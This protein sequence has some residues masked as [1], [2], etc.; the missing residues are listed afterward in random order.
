VGRDSIVGIA[1]RYGLDGPGSNPGGGTDV[2]QPSRPALRP[3]QAPIQWIPVFLGDKVAG[4]VVA[5]AAILPSDE[6]KERVALYHPS[7]SGPSWPGL[8]WTLTFTILPASLISF[9]E[10]VS[11][12]HM[13][14]DL[15][16]RFE[17]VTLYR[18]TCS[19][20]S[21]RLHGI[22]LNTSLSIKV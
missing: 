22:T 21:S 11:C 8:G 16:P 2:L 20:L 17:I 4:R 15:I 5:W 6:V 7:P 19:Q 14:G 9:R 10:E 13:G 12:T 3:T 1:A 18:N